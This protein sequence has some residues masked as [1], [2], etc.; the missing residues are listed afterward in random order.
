MRCATVHRDISH[1]SVRFF[2]LL[3]KPLVDRDDLATNSTYHDIP[4]EPSPLWLNVETT[5]RK[6]S[7]LTEKDNYGTWSV[8]TEKA[9]K[10]L[11]AGVQL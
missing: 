8:S 5:V 3:D 4:S 1:D 10:K 7:K 9:L 2:D 6:R 11:K